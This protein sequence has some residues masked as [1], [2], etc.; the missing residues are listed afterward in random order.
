MPGRR[1]PPSERRR[2]LGATVMLI[3][4]LALVPAVATNALAQP[5]N[6]ATRSATARSQAAGCS[7]PERVQRI[8]F[9]ATK[10]A[11]I[12]AHYRRALRAGW[13]R[14]LII[15]RRGADARRDRLL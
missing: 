11:N 8:S 13:P 14:T 2:H 3:I 12:R 5:A 7:Q 9:S 10:Y 6:D 4:C 15:N 1:R